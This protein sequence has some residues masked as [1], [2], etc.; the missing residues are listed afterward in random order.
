MEV[1]ECCIGE[2]GRK[3]SRYTFV[4]HPSMAQHI[5][6]LKGAENLRG[7]EYLAQQL[8]ARGE[9]LYQ[10]YLPGIREMAH[11]SLF[12][13]FPERTMLALSRGEGRPC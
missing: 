2:R 1:P 12:A 8:L 5:E 4:F 9:V 11:G 10:A 3:V 7:G 13:S 6:A